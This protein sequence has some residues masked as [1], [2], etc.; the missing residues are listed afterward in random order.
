MYPACPLADLQ[1]DQPRYVQAGG[2]EL[3]VVLHA[4]QV[5]ALSNRCGHMS[6]ALHRGQ[7]TDGVVVCGLHGAGFH[8]TDGSVAWPAIIPPPISDYM[9]DE[10]PRIREFGELIFGCATLPVP[11]FPVEVREG[12]VYVQLPS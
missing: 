9:H 12:L 1:P 6:A 4:G 5:Y 7:F 10:N 2:H 11:S 3:F 8:V